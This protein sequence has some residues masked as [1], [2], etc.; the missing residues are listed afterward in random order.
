MDIASD[1]EGKGEENITAMSADGNE[2]VSLDR[3][4]ICHQPLQL[5]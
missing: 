2:N 4:M 3:R 1:V 5:N